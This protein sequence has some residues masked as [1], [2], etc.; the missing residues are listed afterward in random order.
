[1]KKITYR[2]NDGSK[3]VVAVGDEF[4]ARYNKVLRE[5]RRCDRKEKRNTISFA[6]LRNKGVEVLKEDICD[7]IDE[8]EESI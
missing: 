7:Q 3:C 1:M 2:F 5:E 6:E 4:Y 8:L